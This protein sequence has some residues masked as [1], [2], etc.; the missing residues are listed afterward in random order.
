MDKSRYYLTSQHS[1]LSPE[2]K[3][4]A[5]TLPSCNHKPLSPLA[6]LSSPYPPPSCPRGRPWCA[7]RCSCCPRGGSWRCRP[8]A[9]WSWSRRWPRRSA[10]CGSAAW[11]R[12]SSWGRGQGGLAA[13]AWQGTQVMAQAAERWRMEHGGVILERQAI[14]RRVMAK[15]RSGSRIGRTKLCNNI[16]RLKLWIF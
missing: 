16:C 10:S 4:S 12:P 15:S 5:L 13:P 14:R 8:R 6:G 9:V 7:G 11:S 3:P 1:T 2:N